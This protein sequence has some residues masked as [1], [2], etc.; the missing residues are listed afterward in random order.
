MKPRNAPKAT[1]KS[2]NRAFCLSCKLKQDYSDLNFDLNTHAK[3]HHPLEFNNI[4]PNSIYYELCWRFKRK[5]GE[6]SLKSLLVTV[7]ERNK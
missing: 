3:T 5:A 7:T 1:L 2:G 4:V 6:L